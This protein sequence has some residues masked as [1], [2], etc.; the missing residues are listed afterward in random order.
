MFQGDFIH[1]LDA[2]NRL[3]IP[4]KFREEL[5]NSFIVCPSPDGCLFVYT[6]DHWKDI[7]MQIAQKSASRRDRIRQRNSLFGVTQVTPD[8][9]GRITL[10]PR[11]I[12]K[13]GLSKEVMIFGMTTRIEIWDL[14]RWNKMMDDEAVGEDGLEDE[15]LY[16]EINY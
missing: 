16:P 5:G 12:E 3:F 8:K 11:L 1:N 10:P 2:K 15:D 9:Q 14:D 13:A 4:A 6:E 7:A